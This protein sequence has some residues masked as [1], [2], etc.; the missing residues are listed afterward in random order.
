MYA[1]CAIRD[2]H[3]VQSFAL[4]ETDIALL[5]SD[6]LTAVP[7]T[8]TFQWLR[9]DNGFEPIPDAIEAVYQA[10]SSGSYAVV[11]VNGMCSDTSSCI[12]IEITATH[13]DQD[14]QIKIYPNPVEDYVRIEGLFSSGETEINLIDIRGHHLPIVARQSGSLMDIDMSSFTSGVYLLEVKE[15]A[16]QPMIFKIIKM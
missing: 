7:D 9:C 6:I 4:P 16:S 3:I 1:G 15:A 2:T 8:G 5:S 10:T 12:T 14:A 11:S 13:D